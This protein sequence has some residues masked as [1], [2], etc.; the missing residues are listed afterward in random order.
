MTSEYGDGLNVN[1]ENQTTQQK[2]GSKP[3]LLTFRHNGTHGR[4]V[5]GASPWLHLRHLLGLAC[6]YYKVLRPL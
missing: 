6:A 4:D 1:I 3:F 2:N 5:P